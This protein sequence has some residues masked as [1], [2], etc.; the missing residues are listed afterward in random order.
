M[1]VARPD[2]ADAPPRTFPACA[3]AI[4]LAILVF[5]GLSLTCAVRSDGF[6]VA[7]ACAHYLYARFAFSDPVN[8]VDVWA[9]PFCTALYAIP[10]RIGGRLGVRVTAL[11]VALGCALVARSIARGQGHRLPALALVL[12]LV[13]PLL[14]VYSFA[15]MTE[16][17]FALLL[18]AAFLAYQNR[19][20]ALAALLAG[21]T[22]TVR[23]EGFGIVLVAAAALILHRRWLALPLLL[24]P[25]L[26]WDLAG[27][28]VT[29]SASPWWRWLFDAWPW[30][31]QGLYGR[32]SIFTF[33]AAL[34]VIVSPL[35]LPATLIGIGH[36]L[37]AIVPAHSETEAR[38]RHRQVCRFLTAAIPVCVLIVHSLLR[39]MGKFGTY[40]EPRYL[41]IVAPF[42]GVLSARGWEWAFFRFNW[43]HPLAWAGAAALTPVLINAIRPAVPIHL[44]A[45]DGDWPTAK[46]F[47]Q[48][49]KQDPIRKSYPL[50]IASHAGIYYFLDEDPNGVA[51]R[52]GFTRGTITHPPAGALL[53]WDPTYSL[54]NA[55]AEEATTLATIHRAGWAEDPQIDVL[56]NGVAQSRDSADPAKLW[57]VFRSPM[58]CHRGSE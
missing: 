17:P 29:A 16:L 31:A 39:A 40:G 11:I 50:V 24:L 38:E 15:E 37:R 57:H 52:A 51:R 53:V 4:A 35:I 47:A 34:P 9:R 19:R 55:N 49:Y 2:P 48:W 41:L 7:D 5:C 28:L 44:S 18:G 58:P 42:W 22:P 27:W 20:W 54:R 36:N 10:A 3:A 33:I 23:P 26:I 43:K 13:Q 14:F 1:T 6:V 12:T 56:L 25:L 8:L 46:R 32:G 21:L 45:M 30:S